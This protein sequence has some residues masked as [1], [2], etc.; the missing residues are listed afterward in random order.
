LKPISFK[1]YPENAVIRASHGQ[2][3]LSSLLEA[4][5]SINHSCGGMGTC[6]TC[7]VT[8]LEGFEKLGEKTEQEKEISDDRKWGIRERLC[9]QIIAHQDLVLKKNYST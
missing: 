5:I 2:T 9:C 3:V 6:G 4:K 7:A 8:V 1:I